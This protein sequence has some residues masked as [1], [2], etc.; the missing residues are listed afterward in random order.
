[1]VRAFS[2]DKFEIANALRETGLLLSVAGGNP[3]K[4]KAYLARLGAGGMVLIYLIDGK[5]LR[6]LLDD[7]QRLE[8]S[9]ALKIFAQVADAM[10]K[11]IG[12]KENTIHRRG[13]STRKRLWRE[14]RRQFD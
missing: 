5:S 7:N 10:E 14:V 6:T 2:M 1:M 13:P 3:F 11:T 12:R 9:R 4:A 8:V